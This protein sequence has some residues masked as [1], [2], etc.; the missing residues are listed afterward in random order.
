[1]DVSPDLC[2]SFPPIGTLP[3]DD[4]IDRNRSKTILGF[5]EAYEVNEWNLMG[6]G[7]ILLLFTDGLTEHLRA[8][9]A[10]FPKRL[11]EKVREVKHLNARAIFDAVKEHFLEF[12]QPSDDASFVV[13]KR[14]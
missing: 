6:R 12:A 8:G 3:S 5:K 14:T 4:V 9:E 2:T 11:E 1:M 7:D 13:I 10:Y